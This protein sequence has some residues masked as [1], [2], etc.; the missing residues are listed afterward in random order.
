MRELAAAPVAR[1]SQEAVFTQPTGP[2]L[3]Y[4]QKLGEN[5][6]VEGNAA[7]QWQNRERYSGGREEAL[8]TAAF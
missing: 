3:N 7:M 1:G 2:S 8:G 6:Y 4:K 5:K